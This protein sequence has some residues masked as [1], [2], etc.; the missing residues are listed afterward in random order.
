[1]LSGTRFCKAVMIRYTGVSIYTLQMHMASASDAPVILHQVTRL[2]TPGTTGYLH[3]PIC[4]HGIARNAAY[5]SFRNCTFH[6]RQIIGTSK[7][8]RRT[9]H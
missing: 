7:I 5:S 9:G 1:M 8:Y 2:R 6:Y 3:S 4:H